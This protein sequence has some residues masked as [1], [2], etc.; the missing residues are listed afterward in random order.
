ML[1]KLQFTPSEERIF[2]LLYEGFLGTARPT[3][4]EE[5]GAVKGILKKLRSMST[6]TNKTIAFY[7]QNDKLS[8]KK[9]VLIP[10]AFELFDD[11]EWQYLTKTANQIATPAMLSDLVMEIYDK[12]DNAPKGDAKELMTIPMTASAGA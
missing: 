7:D 8:P 6:E 10:D 3:S 5:H 4:R 11:G 9:R 12:L 1:H 2:E